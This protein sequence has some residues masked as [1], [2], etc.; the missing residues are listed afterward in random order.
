MLKRDPKVTGRLQSKEQARRVAW[1]I[2][3][4][5]ID[6]QLALVEVRLVSLPEVFLPYA[7][8]P[9]S[10]RTLYEELESGGLRLL[11]DGQA[12]EA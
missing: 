11:T 6:A 7:V 3:K 9:R 8:S 10:G 4:D 5:W 2:I 12:G 1:R